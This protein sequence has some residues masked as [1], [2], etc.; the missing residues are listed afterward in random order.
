MSV[1]ERCEYDHLVKI[2]EATRTLS[3]YRVRGE[4][5]EFY[6]SVQLPDTCWDDDPEAAEIFC[7]MLGENLIFDSPQA[8]RILRP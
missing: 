3:I 5:T 8:R 1:T 4:E 2:D 6:T 7:R